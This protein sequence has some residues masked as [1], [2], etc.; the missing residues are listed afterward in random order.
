MRVI[1]KRCILAIALAAGFCATA[2]AGLYSYTYSGS[3][4]NI[5][6][7]NLSGWSDSHTFSGLPSVIRNITVTLNLSGGYNGDL[8]AYLSHGGVLLPLLNR[9]GVGTGSGFGYST[10]GLNVTL[11]DSGSLNIHGVSAPASGGTY[12]P[13]GRV[14]SP[15]SPAGDFT[16][17]GSVSFSSAFG[18]LNPN[19]VWTLFVADV[20]GGGGQSVLQGWSLDIDTAVPEPVNVALGVFGILFGAV[21]AVRVARRLMG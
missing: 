18:Q 17:A 2:R 13:D 9:V 19:G 4:V 12:E 8:Y 7:G 11:S 21:A 3:P 1:V 20:S 16:S 6:D 14:I 5:Q 15:F 10:A